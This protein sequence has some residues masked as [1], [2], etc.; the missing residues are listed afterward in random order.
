MGSKWLWDNEGA[1]R[2]WLDFL[3]RHGEDGILT[4]VPT[5]RPLSEYPSFGH[6]P[7]GTAYHVPIEDLGN[8]IGL[9]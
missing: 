4:Q 1:A 3:R 7:Q 6:P 8:A 9:F 5:R 2:G